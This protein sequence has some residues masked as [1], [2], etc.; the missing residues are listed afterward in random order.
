MR[1]PRPLPALPLA[2]LGTALITGTLCPA[3]AQSPARCAFGPASPHFVPV[4]GKLR[5]LVV[6]DECRFVYLANEATDSVEVFSIERGQLEQPIAVGDAPSGLDLSPDG[7]FLYVA[8]S[9]ALYVSVVDLASRQETVQAAMPPGHLPTSL[10]VASSGLVIIGSRDGLLQLDP[11]TNVISVRHFGS[12]GAASMRA[13]GDR[14]VIGAV[15]Q[16]GAYRYEPDS[17]VWARVATLS[18]YTGDVAM[19]RSASRMFISQRRYVFDASLN[20]LGTCNGAGD[21]VEV[22]PQGGVGYQAGRSGLEIVDLRTF[23]VTGTLPIGDSLNDASSFGYGSGQMAISDDGELLAI[24][25]D[26]GFSLLRTGIERVSQLA[27]LSAQADLALAGSKDSFRIIG[28]LRLG[29]DSDGLDPASENV[30]VHV[31]VFSAT[32]PAGG[33]SRRGNRFEFEGDLAGA[34]LRVSLRPAQAQ[35]WQISVEGRGASLAGS[36]VPLEV[37]LRIGD[38]EGR[39]MLGSGE[40]ELEARP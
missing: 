4:T 5:E 14:H 38:D 17:D 35:R 26:H 34:H 6:D 31:G 28:R 37:A 11:S 19:D 29:E 21:K 36:S 32:V 9:G 33:F 12:F 10:A 27:S 24:I 15:I 40:A 18:S 16:D 13:S 8:N 2:A 25:T 3:F 39:T 30:T 20:L 1:L 7:K 22:D 23:L